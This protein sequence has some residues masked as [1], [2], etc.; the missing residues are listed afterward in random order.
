MTTVDTSHIHKIITWMNI[1]AGEGICF[2]IDGQLV[3]A[4]DLIFDWF[5]DLMD[6]WGD[7]SLWPKS[8]LKELRGE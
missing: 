4:D 1:A 2:E 8:V 7:H 5:G 3:G 6:G